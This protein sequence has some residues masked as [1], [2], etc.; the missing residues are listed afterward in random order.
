MGGNSCN[1]GLRGEHSRSSQSTPLL[2]LSFI[3]TSLISASNICT[4]IFSHLAFF[5]GISDEREQTARQSIP[6][7]NRPQHAVHIFVCA[8][9]TVD[10]GVALRPRGTTDP[11][12]APKPKPQFEN[13]YQKQ[14][15]EKDKSYSFSYTPGTPAAGGRSTFNRFNKNP[16]IFNATETAPFDDDQPPNGYDGDDDDFQASSLPPQPAQGRGPSSS[17]SSSSSGF[18]YPSPSSTPNAARGGPPQQQQQ[19]HGNS[20][21]QS[22][23]MRG[24][25]GRPPPAVAFPQPRPPTFYGNAPPVPIDVQLVDRERFGAAE[26]NK[27]DKWLSDFYASVPGS[28]FDACTKMWTFPLSCYTSFTK[29]IEDSRGVTLN[30]PLPPWIMRLFVYKEKKPLNMSVQL[31]KIPVGLL[32]ALYPFQREGVMFAL[33]RNGRALIADEMGLGKTLQAI[34]IAAYYKEDWPVLVVAPSSVRVQWADNFEKWIPGLRPD[35]IKVIMKTKDNPD[36]LVNIISYDLVVRQTNIAQKK[37]R[38]IIAD[39]SHTIKSWKAK[40]T[41]HL[42]PLLKDARRCILLTGTPALSRPE[43][44]FTQLHALDSQVFVRMTDFGVRYCAGHQTRFCW[45]YSGSSNLKELNLLLQ[46]TVMIRRL[47]CD[48]LGQLPAKKRMQVF[49]GIIDKH[50]KIIGNINDKIKEHKKMFHIAHSTDAAKSARFEAWRLI[51]ELY[52][53]TGTAKLPAVTEYIKEMLKTKNKIIVFAYH[54]DVMD[55]IGLLLERE[56]VEYVRI[57]GMTPPQHRQELVDYYQNQPNCR[58]AVLGLTSAGVGLTMTKAEAVIM[59]ELYWNPGILRQ[60][61]DR[62]HRIGVE[63]EVE[64]FYLVARGTLDESI[65][66]EGPFFALQPALQVVVVVVG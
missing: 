42:Q 49:L 58:A 24:A 25:G 12:P 47:K 9:W 56:G 55:G 50:K 10:V 33:Q 13:P 19:H 52:H 26:P 17:S 29:A 27:R 5:C 53:N 28:T 43:E 37:F 41:S 39:E 32:N 16:S 62:A 51:K 22:A 59:T 7:S 34:A 64:V 23:A 54:H 65:W 57:D 6:D 60:A 15:E 61:E 18:T 46:E 4:S 21:Q 31:D 40:R 45:D 8:A 14:Q 30:G 38:V 1:D 66:Y 36:G 2:Q 3:S 48:V 63:H 44:L 35:Q 20:S 11:C